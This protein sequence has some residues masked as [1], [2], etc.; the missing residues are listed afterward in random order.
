[1]KKLI[2]SILALLT[3]FI[4]NFSH[5]QTGGKISG[6]V[7]DENKK[8]LDGAT[9]ILLTTKDSTQISSQLAKTD[10]S[11][12]FLNLKD[13]TYLVKVTFVGYKD[14]RSSQVVISQQNAVTLQSFVL[15]PAGKSLNEVSVT[16]QRSYVQQK[17]DRTVVNVGALASN[18]GANAL[19]VLEKTPGVQVDEDGNITFKGKSGVLVMIDDK[20]GRAHV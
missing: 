3:L 13:N 7:L 4:F 5:A 9:V 2:L 11:F 8:P 10:G 15:S 19:E 16:S 6:S 17:I 20:I 14:F 12:A 1:M 18:T